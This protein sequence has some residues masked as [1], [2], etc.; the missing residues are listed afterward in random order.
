MMKILYPNVYGLI[1]M[2]REIWDIMDDRK[3]HVVCLPETKLKSR[4]TNCK[5]GFENYKIWRKETVTKHGE[6]IN[7]ASDKLQ[8]RQNHI[9]TSNDVEILADEIKMEDAIGNI[10]MPLLARSW[11][12]DEY[13]K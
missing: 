11:D 1:F 5:F 8:A 10:Y 6:V 12:K 7:I 9:D 2:L 13:E 4:I 3:Q